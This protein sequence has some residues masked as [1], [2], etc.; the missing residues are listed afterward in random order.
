MVHSRICLYVI[1]LLLL[2]LLTIL[3]FLETTKMRASSFVYLVV[4]SRCL[5]LAF[6]EEHH[7]RK[8]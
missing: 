4:F 8:I 5:V 7:K 1:I 3:S 2:F 6:G